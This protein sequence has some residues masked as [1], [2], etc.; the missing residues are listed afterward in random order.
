MN[1]LNSLIKYLIKI[2]ILPKSKNKTKKKE[3][4][5]LKNFETIKVKLIYEKNK[6]DVKNL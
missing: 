3:K 6:S 4:A 5:F 1:G 2:I